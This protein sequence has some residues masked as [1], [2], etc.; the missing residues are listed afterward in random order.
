MHERTTIDDKVACLVHLAETSSLCYQEGLGLR[1]LAPVGNE[2]R[3]VFG[4]KLKCGPGRTQFDL[5]GIVK[6]FLFPATYELLCARK[7]CDGRM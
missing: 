3:F 7:D 5:N 6:L 1:V 2:S 4:E